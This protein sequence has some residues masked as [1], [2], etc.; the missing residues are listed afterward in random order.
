MGLGILV[1]LGYY[2]LLTSMETLAS[3]G[4]L[5][6]LIA[7]W[8]PNFV[9]IAMGI[10]LLIKTANESPIQ[11]FQWLGQIMDSITLKIKTFSRTI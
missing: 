6:P 11:I 10:Y 3:N 2:V 7:S 8:A 9:L 5:P 4:N 1:V